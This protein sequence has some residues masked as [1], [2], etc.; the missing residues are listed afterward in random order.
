M[1]QHIEERVAY[2]RKVRTR[3]LALIEAHGPARAATLARA[4]ACEPGAAE[5]DRQF[6]LAVAA[7]ID[8]L[9]GDPVWHPIFGQPEP[10]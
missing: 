9:N 6:W 10:L 3:A 8:R 7:R 1:W 5:A 2:G 4:A